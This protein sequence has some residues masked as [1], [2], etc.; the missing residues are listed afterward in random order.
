MS[1]QAFLSAISQI[2]FLALFGIAALRLARR[3]SWVTLDAF[4]F[5]GAIA[6]L[7]VI[8]DAV[9]WLSI[10]AP[11][12]V[13]TITWVGVTALPYLLLRLVD[14]FRPQPTFL[15]V[16]AALAYGVVALIGILAPQPW[17][18]AVSLVSVSFFVVLG[19]YASLAFL[20][21]AMRTTGVT[22]RR[23]V[24]V[25][26]GSGSLAG[27]L[28]LAGIRVVWPDAGDVIAVVSQVMTLIVVFSYFVG[29][30]P[31]GFLRRAWQEPALRSMLIASPGLVRLPDAAAV[32]AHFERQAAAATGAE[33]ARL[34]IWNE[35]QGFL[36][37]GEHPIGQNQIRPGEFVSGRAFERQ[38]TIYTSR[39]DRDAP[40]HADEYRKTGIQAL[41]STPVTS[42]G[43]RL[44]VLTVYAARPPA[45]TDD[46]V[47]IL[48][49][50]AE[51]VAL[52]LRSRQLLDEAAHV[53]ALAE[54][55]RLKNDFLSVVAHDVRTPLT[56]ILLNVEML[57]QAPAAD[58]GSARRLTSLRSEAIRLRDLVEDY[59]SL[60]RA[61]EVGELRL[62]DHDLAGLVRET[63][64]NMA[65]ADSRV[66]M[67]GDTSV[68][69]AFDARR[70]AQLVQN[71]V[72]NAFKYSEEGVDV[73]VRTEG[74]E[75]VIEVRDHGIGVPKADLPRLFE[76]FHRGTNTDD[77]RHS[78]MGLGL[79]I[80]RQI[81]EA[82]G[83]SI[84]VASRVGE[85]SSFV[86]RLPRRH[87]TTAPA[88]VAEV[89]Q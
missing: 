55:T 6:V 44:G 83:G 86:V 40:E 58:E 42:D 51:Q 34:G 52:V 31:P 11:E 67:G 8:G 35:A 48:E 16:G 88:D 29:F 63:V 17:S 28:L 56:T 36:Q 7:L 78:G 64:D 75:A 26:I 81:A 19:M 32:G 22:K 73:D 57:Q 72:G 46:V 9:R 24:A 2:A 70:I 65:E 33:G 66:R 21:E 82:H 60:M 76:R 68:V 30:A 13:A 85:G 89:A 47:G 14:D 25:A 12:I 53:Q 61:E 20:R 27:V 87:A 79:Y 37:F 5:F 74:P 23:M 50:V 71:L 62:A 69:G 49:L 10:D 1:A 45:F 77:R 15:M 18:P 3:V 84:S 80:C 54:V 38:E 59:L 39:P 4:A 41:V 43:L